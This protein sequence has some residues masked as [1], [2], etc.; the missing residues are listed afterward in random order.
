MENAQSVIA[1]YDA[2]ILPSR[3]DGWGIVVN[4]AFLQGVPVIV[5][6]HVG[7]KCLIESNVTGIIFKSEN[8]DDL[9]NHLTRLLE[10]PGLMDSIYA[11]AKTVYK[12]ILPEIAA[13]YFLDALSNHFYDT[14]PRPQAIWRNQND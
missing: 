14:G 5:S 10:T 7:S 8:V 12:H 6:D 11:N 1:K 3:H 2:L 13:Q 4:E 9:T